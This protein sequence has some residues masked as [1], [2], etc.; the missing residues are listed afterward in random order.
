LSSPR[1]F[2]VRK[3]TQLTLALAGSAVAVAAIAAGATTAALAGPARAPGAPHRAGV[4][5]GS[6]HA[7]AQPAA[8]TSPSSP[9][10]HA[11]A[12]TAVGPA[13]LITPVG[14]PGLAGSDQ[15]GPA[16]FANAAA[17]L[18]A[19]PRRIARGLMPSFHWS[20]GGQFRYLNQLWTQESRW[21]RHAQN[22]DTGAYGIPQAVPGS[23]M[24]SAGPDWRSDV[25]TQIR[26]GLGY[27]QGR[28][29]SPRLAWHHEVAWGWY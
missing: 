13:S 2:R 10:R 3:P 22:P 5:A 1:T 18:P 23:K 26:W 28:Y 17:R 7:A 20:V 25:A 19:T 9:A 16:L 14:P 4:A 11:A 21:N 27:I 15:S 6:A 24:S 8:Q 12:G 29:G